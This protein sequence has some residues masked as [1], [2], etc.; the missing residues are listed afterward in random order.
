MSKNEEKFENWATILG[1]KMEDAR[2][3]LLSLSHDEILVDFTMKFAAFAYAAYEFVLETDSD[4]EQIAWLHLGE[5]YRKQALSYAVSLESEEDSRDLVDSI[6]N[7]LSEIRNGAISMAYVNDSALEEQ[8][9]E[10]LQEM[11]TPS[12]EIAESQEEILENQETKGEEVSQDEN[13][14]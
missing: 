10:A 5:E 8:E 7:L 3:M 9:G 2:E 11:G 6:K 13:Q 14:G 12:S 1:S 4:M